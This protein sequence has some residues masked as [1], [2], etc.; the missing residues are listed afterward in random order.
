MTTMAEKQRELDIMKWNDSVQR[1]Q[2]C[3]G[4]YEFCA[5]C[6]KSQDYPCA[7]AFE[8]H[9]EK[10]S[11]KAPKPAASRSTS[12]RQAIRAPRNR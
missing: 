6:D 4:S 7:F 12:G 1:G 5:D 8:K 11:V 9:G 2:D 3:C 10:K